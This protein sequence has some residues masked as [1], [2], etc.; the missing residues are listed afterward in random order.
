MSEQNSPISRLRFSG[1]RSYAQGS[2]VPIRRSPAE[3]PR[4]P[5]RV[6]EPESFVPARQEIFISEQGVLASLREAL[7]AWMLLNEGRIEQ[8]RS[9]P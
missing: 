7:L 6:A 5:E 4:S 9:R 3:L 8:V 1:P 2:V